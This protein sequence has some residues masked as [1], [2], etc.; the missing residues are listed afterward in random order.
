MPFFPT[1]SFNFLSI[2]IILTFFIYIKYGFIILKYFDD[3]KKM[4]KRDKIKIEFTINLFFFFNK[5]MNK[6]KKNKKAIKKNK[7]IIYN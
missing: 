3:Y 4:K 2:V 5:Y 1:N 6:K 7:L